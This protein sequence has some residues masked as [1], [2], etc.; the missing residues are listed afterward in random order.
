MVNLISDKG[1][2][3]GSLKH[4][5]QLGRNVVL[6]EMIQRWGR[7]SLWFLSHSAPGRP[8]NGG[9]GTFSIPSS[10]PAFNETSSPIVD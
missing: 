8:H 2:F 6:S 9:C 5:E 10:G 7:S 4:R 3:L 1:R